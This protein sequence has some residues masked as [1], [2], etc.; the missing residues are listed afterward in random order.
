MP[1]ITQ[2]RVRVCSKTVHENEESFKICISFKRMFSCAHPF[3]PWKVLHVLRSSS[4]ICCSLELYKTRLGQIFGGHLTT[5]QNKA[6]LEYKSGYYADPFV[7]LS[8]E[9][10]REFG[11][12][13]L[14]LET[15]LVLKY[16]M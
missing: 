7:W 10:L 9:H 2:F 11:I 13:Q 4:N 15:V 1:Q 16:A 12:L 8:F 6:G 14:T 3:S 5:P